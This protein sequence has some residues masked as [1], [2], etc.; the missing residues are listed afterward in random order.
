MRNF[1]KTSLHSQ[2]ELSRCMLSASLAVEEVRAGI[3]WGH[4]TS[5][6]P[7]SQCLFIEL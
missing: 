2:K 3:D 5:V 4:D 6:G 1:S 7:A